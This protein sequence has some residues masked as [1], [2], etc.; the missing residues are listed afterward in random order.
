MQAELGRPNALQPDKGKVAIFVDCSPVA[1]PMFEVVY[2][3]IL[4]FPFLLSLPCL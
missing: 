3:Y 2:F 4:P 1:E